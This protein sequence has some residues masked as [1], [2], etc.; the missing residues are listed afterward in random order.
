LSQNGNRWPMPSAPH[1]IP[2]SDSARGAQRFVLS[3]AP[4]RR[5]VETGL[6]AASYQAERLASSAERSAT[7]GSAAS[8]R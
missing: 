5:I 3:R 6:C 8:S 7:G 2:A 1:S 4:E